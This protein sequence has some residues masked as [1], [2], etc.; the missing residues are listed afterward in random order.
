M[1][2]KLDLLLKYKELIFS[3]S[4]VT[5]GI[6]NLWLGTKLAPLAFDIRNLAGR[7][8]AVESTQSS[9]ADDVTGIKTDVTKIKCYLLPQECLK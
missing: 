5:L 4:V 8:S 2:R 3:I 7:V 1:S 9:L 6:L